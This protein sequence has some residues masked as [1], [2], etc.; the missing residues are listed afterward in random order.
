MEYNLTGKILYPQ[1]TIAG[2]SGYC[3]YWFDL[4]KADD[5]REIMEIQATSSYLWNGQPAQHH[6][7][8]AWNIGPGTTWVLNWKN[9]TI[10]PDGIPHATMTRFRIKTVHS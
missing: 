5:A 10:D 8:P 3:G 1:K 7:H 2:G 9:L 4:T 6:P